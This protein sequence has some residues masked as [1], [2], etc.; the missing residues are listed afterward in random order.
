MTACA[1]NYQMKSIVIT[2]VMVAGRMWGAFSVAFASDQR[3]VTGIDERALAAVA[4]IISL[5]VSRS[6]R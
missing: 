4:S 3:R 6:G 1:G 2:P 5:A